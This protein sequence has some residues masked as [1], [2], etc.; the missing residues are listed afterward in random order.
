VAKSARADLVSQACILAG[1]LNPH[2]LTPGWL[3]KEGILPEGSEKPEVTLQIPTMAPQ[4]KMSGI[5]WF[6]TPDRLDVRALEDREGGEHPGEIVARILAKLP[7]TPVTA[8]GNNFH[9]RLPQAPEA[10]AAQIESNLL[11][12]LRREMAEQIQAKEDR[13]TLSLKVPCLSG[14]IL[15]LTIEPH[16]QSIVRFNFHHALATWEAAATA[17]RGWPDELAHARTLAEWLGGV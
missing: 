7:H 10:L 3:V 5:S 1:S 17:A 4:F 9:F 12:S 15:N 13:V 8:V 14:A 11:K 16:R 6:A 2:I